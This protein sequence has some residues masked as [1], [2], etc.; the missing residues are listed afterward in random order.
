MDIDGER[1]R[2]GRGQD[3]MRRAGKGLLQVV[4][5]LLV[6]V[7]AGPVSA[8]HAEAPSVT[9]EGLPSLTTTTPTI[10][11]MAAT[12][13]GDELSVS[14]TIFQE[15]SVAA[16]GQPSVSFNGEWRYTPPHLSDGSYTVR[17]T[18]RNSE[19]GEEAT[20]ERA[21]RIDST[22]PKVTI[23]APPPVTKIAT[24]TLGGGAG[25][26]EG[27]QG[28]SVTIYQG[29]SAG[30]T[31]AASGSASMGGA[32][33]SYTAPTLIDG[34]YTAQAT[35]GDWVGHVSHSAAVTF[36]VETKSP[37]VTL[38]PVKT[39]SNN[40]TPSFA[41]TATNTTPVTVNIYAGAV[42]T[43]TP[44]ATVTAAGNEKT[45][46]SGPAAVLKDG[47]YTAVATQLSSLP[48]EIPPGTSLPVT[49]VV[50]TVAPT[51]TLTSPAT[52]SNNRKPSFKGTASDTK[53]P[54]I[55]KVY[56]GASETG[57]PVA[58][59]TA[60]PPAAGVWTS[61]PSSELKEGIHEYTAVATQRSS[62]ENPTGKSPPVHFIVDTN[63]PAVT[64]NSPP[65]LSNNPTLTFSGTASE[66]TPVTVNIYA[67]A[68]A[69]GPVAATATAASGGV[70][71][72]GPT[73]PA[74]KDGEYTAT[75]TQTS[76]VGDPGDSP[77]VTFSIYTVPPS[78]TLSLPANGSSTAGSSELIAGSAGTAA[79]DLPVVTV[80]VFTGGAIA[81][82]QTPIQSINV[83]A[84]AGAWST[85]VAGLSSGTYTVR[86]LQ[87]D[88]A[89]NV[90]VSAT[91]TFTVGGALSATHGPPSAS[92]SW[93]P[94]SPHTGESVSLLSSS[95]DAV[96][97]ITAYAWDLAGSGGFVAGGPVTSTSFSTPGRHLV[98]LRVNDA[99]GLSSVASEAIEVTP[100]QFQLMQ[101]FPVVRITG[102]RVSSGVRLKL[103][104]VQASSAAR[105]TVTC[106]GHGCPVKSQTRAASAGKVRSGSIQ[107]RRLERF[108]PGGV[109]LQIR[110]SKPGMIGKYTRF[111]VRRSRP[112][113]RF[114]TCLGP[115]GI[116][117]MTCPSS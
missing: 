65:L 21:L 37:T 108:L 14:V 32:T 75:A 82:G 51:V 116:R 49:F 113:A 6:V 10:E 91:A 38:S 115:A 89:H 63:A 103:L 109:V 90:G 100:P 101:P 111:T 18:Q 67:G 44:V 11:G 35:Q 42:A 78:V 93:V 20:A 1:S 33:W 46:T 68:T 95:T 85:T 79:I 77:P 50:N 117:P 110:V 43:G 94:A 15:G 45:W 87:A 12:G 97:P 48:A 58:E 34:T 99:S 24:P 62:I 84:V 7:A 76:S 59:V 69:T 98:Q 86:A 114:D 66:G 2:R 56:L 27:D 29:K 72:S 4:V 8:A 64:L 13:E 19:S 73:S 102:T 96:S 28:V 54:I 104:S 16:S 5:L 80:Q 17:A 60:P 40:K 105:I 3:P 83:N 23:N 55:V 57:A 92:F 112:P 36:K 25:A 22:A 88:Q 71:S 30:G 26:E 41:G 61:G 47:E 9:I 53:E 52:R 81:G 70:W 106:T 107:F 39:P 74:L 31:V